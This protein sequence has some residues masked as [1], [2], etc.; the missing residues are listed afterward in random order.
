MGKEIRVGDGCRFG[1]FSIIAAERI[2]I[3]KGADIGSFTFLSA[4]EISIG[5]DSVIHEFVFSGI[6]EGPHSVLNIG[7]R[8]R[9]FP[10]TVINPTMGVNI[11]DDV[12][13]GGYS[14]I[15][16]HGVWQSALQG[17]PFKYAPVTIR[18]GAWLPWH[19]FVL[20]G[21]TIGE[22]ATV[23]ASSLITSDIPPKSLALGVP[24]KIVRTGDQYPKSLSL[25]EREQILM[26]IFKEFAE[27][28][29][30]KGCPAKFEALGTSFAVRVGELQDHVIRYVKTSADMITE[31][32]E[33]P[34]LVSLTRVPDTLA[35]EMEAQSVCWMDLEN[36]KR[37]R[38]TNSVMEDF[39]Q[40]LFRYGIKAIRLDEP[41]G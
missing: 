14:L 36:E 15:F 23:G 22:G 39:V 2:H 29:V 24:A 1:F 21:V 33:T 16:T 27:N 30:Y 10:L 6:L 31:K 4:R 7:K 20:P 3:G 40:F 41:S 32:T 25:E 11:E 18:K 37:G 38:A 26:R 35:R 13:V 28:S 19:V 9:V 8:V 17:Y 34:I 12:G 5:D